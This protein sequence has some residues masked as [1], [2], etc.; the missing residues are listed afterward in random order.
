VADWWNCAEVF[1]ATLFSRNT[2]VTCQKINT[3]D[4]DRVTDCFQDRTR[5]ERQGR[6]VSIFSPR[7]GATIIFRFR[8]RDRFS[9][10][11]L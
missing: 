11:K 1:L 10:I 7:C 5:E 9:E 3:S 8:E 2:Y 6:G 4:A